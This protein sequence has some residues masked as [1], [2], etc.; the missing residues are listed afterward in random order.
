MP[1]TKSLK[2][3]SCL[4]S[5]DIN[6]SIPTNNGCLESWANNG[7]LLI[8]TFLTVGEKPLSHKDVGWD[9]FIETVLKKLN[10]KDPPIAFLLWGKLAGEKSLLLNE[11]R[12]RVIKSYHPLQRRTYRHTKEGYCNF[13][14]DSHKPFSQVSKFLGCNNDELWRL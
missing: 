2:K 9:I 7:I 3:I 12:H 4:L 5:Q 14:D 10:T 11:K 1:L 6:Y 13:C 8:N